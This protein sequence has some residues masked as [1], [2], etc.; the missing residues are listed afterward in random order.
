MAAAK[1][2]FLERA[3]KRRRSNGSR[4]RPTC[5]AHLL[6]VLPLEARG[7]G[8]GRSGHVG[9]YEAGRRHAG[10]TAESLDDRRYGRVGPLSTWAARGRTGRGRSYGDRR[11]GWTARS[12]N[13]DG[14]T[15]ATTPR[16]IGKQLRGL[17][18]HAETDP[19]YDGLMVMAI[20][21]S[22]LADGHRVGG[23]DAVIVDVAARA[24]EALV[25]RGVTRA[26]IRVLER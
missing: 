21:D 4:T 2:Q 22:L 5:P 13:P 24:I 17:G 14:R 1:A 7:F 18:G 25:R 8:C 15:V 20:L 11:P 23:S 10:R 3:T 19:V 16:K 12:S 6:H 9:R 26:R